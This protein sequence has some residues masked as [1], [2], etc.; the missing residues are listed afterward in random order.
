MKNVTKH[1]VTTVTQKNSE[2]DTLV[3]EYFTREGEEFFDY[4]SLN[5]IPV[6]EETFNT[7]SEYAGKFEWINQ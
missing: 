6:T 1:E 4:V 7:V 5:G 3:V 2:G